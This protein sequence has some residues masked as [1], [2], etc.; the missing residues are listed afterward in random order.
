MPGRPLAV[1]GPSLKVYNGRSRD[2]ASDFSKIWF[3]RQKSRIRFSSS[4]PLYR[5]DTDLNSMNFFPNKNPECYELAPGAKRLPWGAKIRARYH[6]VSP[7]PVWLSGLGRQH[8]L[9]VTRSRG[10]IGRAY[11]AHKPFG[12]RLRDDLHRDPAG[13][14]TVPQSL[15]RGRF[16]LLL[17]FFAVVATQVL[18]PTSEMGSQSTGAP[19]K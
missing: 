6:P 8:K 9:P 11:W 5:P 4:G 3:A 16:Q 17:P 15:V 12:R 18:A 1:G 14:H 13:A 19:G 10:S 7:P 2:C